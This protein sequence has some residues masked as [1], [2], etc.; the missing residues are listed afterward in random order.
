MQPYYP[1]PMPQGMSGGAP[2]NVVP[3]YNPPPHP[4]QQGMGGYQMMPGYMPAP[5]APQRYAGP[6]SPRTASSPRHMQPPNTGQMQQQQSPVS[7]P[8]I[9]NPHSAGG[10]VTSPRNPKSPQSAASAKNSPLSLAS[11]T[12]PYNTTDPQ[13]KNYN[14]Q[15]LMSLG[16]RLRQAILARED[17]AARIRGAPLWRRLQSQAHKNLLWLGDQAILPCQCMSKQDKDS[18]EDM[19]KRHSCYPCSRREKRK[20]KGRGW[21]ATTILGRDDALSIVVVI[22]GGW[23]CF[24]LSMVQSLCSAFFE[25]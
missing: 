6:E 3:S 7:S 24:T 20:K 9:Q 16:E 12:S 14:A 18:Q 23:S 17:P 19:A 11:I 10:G 8:V 13:S 2:S 1:M 22:V 21:A 5:Q 15:T 4:P 25:R